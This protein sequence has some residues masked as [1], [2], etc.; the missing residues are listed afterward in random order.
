MASVN[1]LT[2]AQAPDKASIEKGINYIQTKTYPEAD[3]KKILDLYKD[4]RVAD[5]SDGLDMVGLSGTGLVDQAIHADWVDLKDFKHVFRGIAVTVRYVPTQKPALPAT[6]ENFKQWEGN[7]YGTY[8]H[9]GFLKILRPGS[10]VVIDD[11]EDKDIG[12]IGSNNILGWV[13]AGAVGV[14]TD[15]GCRDT[16]EV[17]LQQVPIYLRKKGRGIRPGRNEIESINRPVVIGGV[18]VCPGDVVVADG[19]GV[20]VV[21]RAVA[22]QVAKF[23]FEILV[24]DKAGRKSLY[25]DLGRPLDKTVK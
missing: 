13:K 5:V 7:W 6:G 23:A 2:V 3:D 10:A 22:E 12:S 19:D 9:E 18:L 1:L 25:E 24:G 11:V 21:P 17:G 16:D 15:A 8:S 14:V 4:L 20:V